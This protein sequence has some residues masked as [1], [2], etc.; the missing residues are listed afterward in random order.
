MAE[1]TDSLRGL[2]LYEPPIG[3]E[4]E[5]L[6]VLED[7]ISSGNHDRALEG[8]L[9]A[10]GTSDDD[11]RLIRLSPAW[12][13]LVEVVP[14]LPRELR[15]CAGWAHPEGLI[16]VPTLFLRGEKTES[17]AYLAGFD[18]LVAAFPHAQQELI[19]GQLHVAH[20]F[21]AQAFAGFVVDFFTGLP[22]ESTA[23]YGSGA[24][25]TG[26]SDAGSIAP[27]ASDATYGV[28]TTLP[29]F[30]PSPMNRW[31][32]GASSN[33]NDSATTGT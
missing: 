26:A 23:A 13:A 32:A 11:F 17:R 20:V 14:T 7:L 30:L 31:A 29:T 19:P 9:R 10:V 3:V 22:E 27:I 28:K 21:A 24:S 33:E 2:V 8:F 15:T 16:E 5:S 12:P 1:Q 18:E 4:R 25:G 6:D